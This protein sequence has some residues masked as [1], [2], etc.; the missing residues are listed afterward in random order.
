MNNGPQIF[1]ETLLLLS[2]HIY[3]QY[4]DIQKCIRLYLQVSQA[5]QAI[6]RKCLVPV[7][8]DIIYNQQADIVFYRGHTVSDEKHLNALEDQ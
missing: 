2:Q 3:S 8:R 1:Q 5:K 4:F 7:Q 6:E